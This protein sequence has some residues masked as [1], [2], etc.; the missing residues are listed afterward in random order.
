M[1]CCPLLI[2]TCAALTACTY[3]RVSATP[4]Q[5]EGGEIGYTYSGRA[6]YGY[7]QAEADR[8]MAETCAAQ[9]KSP[10][11]VAQ[12]TSPIGGGAII[13]GAVATVGFNRQQEVV[14]TCR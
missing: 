4:V 2:L 12:Q 7:Q 3:A 8:V 1:R 13:N 5:L 10:L 9:G 6:N 11:I 14:F